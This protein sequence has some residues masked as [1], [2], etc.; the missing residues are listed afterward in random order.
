MDWKKR[1]SEWIIFLALWLVIASPGLFTQWK[2]PYSHG[3]PA[4][5]ISHHLSYENGDKVIFI[6]R[7]CLNSLFRCVSARQARELGANRAQMCLHSNTANVRMFQGMWHASRGSGGRRAR[8][9]RCCSTKV[10]G[11]FEVI[12][13][14]LVYYSGCG[15]LYKV[16]STTFGEKVEH[17]LD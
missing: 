9:P 8:R 5:Y 4:I 13:A 15:T 7:I 17:T 11:P 14:P 12:A 2:A 16:Q 6:A 3:L 1:S 10:I